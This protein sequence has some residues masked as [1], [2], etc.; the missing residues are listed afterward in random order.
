[1]TAPPRKLNYLAHLKL[2]SPSPIPVGP[3]VVVVFKATRSNRVKTVLNL[4]SWVTADSRPH[5]QMDVVINAA[6]A[7]VQ[8]TFRAF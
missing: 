4:Q 8:E 3:G 2:D 1:M 7:S 6:E 5:V